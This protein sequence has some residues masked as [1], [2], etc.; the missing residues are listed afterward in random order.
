MGSRFWLAVTLP[1]LVFLQ[2]IPGVTG[3]YSI[4]P[5]DSPVLG[6]VGNGAILP[7]QLQGK[8]IPEKLSIQWI[9]SGSSTESA[10][11]TFDGKNP[12]NPFLEFEGYWG[13]TEF[14]PSEF[15]QGNLSL[16]LKN[17][18]PSDKGKYTCSVFLDNWYDQVVVELDVAAQG[19]EPSVFL[20]GHAGNGISLSCRSQG[21]V[22]APSVVWLDSQGQ[23][24]PEEVTTQSTPS[25]SS[26][27]FDVVSSMSL[28][29][30]SDREVSCRV[31]NEVLN[32]TRESRVRIA[33][34]F[35]PSTSPWMIA[36]LIILSVDLGILG[37]G[38]YKMKRSFL[39]TRKAERSRKEAAAEKDRLKAEL[40]FSRS[41]AEAGKL[42]RTQRLGKR[43][44]C[45]G[46]ACETWFM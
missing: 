24:R 44:F 6:V 21:W 16:L 10:V 32:A 22:P 34:S 28:E 31:V 2:I 20:D 3:Q 27:I 23:T 39:E 4:I 8:I 37:A 30:G 14:F 29:P 42:E 17:V 18:H 46:V 9:L 1:V 19:A 36:S 38:V 41:T 45:V 35:F 26:G 43:L 7:C 11:A 25:P 5:P 33:D 12:Q 15:H 40:E 13:R